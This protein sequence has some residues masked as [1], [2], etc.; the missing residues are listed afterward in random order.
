MRSLVFAHPLLRLCFDKTGAIEIAMLAAEERDAGYLSSL[1]YQTNSIRIVYF[2]SE[3]VWPCEKRHT[4]DSYQFAPAILH[5]E[6]DT[7]DIDLLK[8]APSVGL[9]SHGSSIC[10]MVT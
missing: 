10:E 9:I 1:R 2:V 8:W 6:A 5:T 4:G 3:I 7:V